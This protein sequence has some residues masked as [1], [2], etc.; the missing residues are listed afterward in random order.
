MCIYNKHKNIGRRYRHLLRNNGFLWE[1]NGSGLVVLRG[2]G[3]S[4]FV[5]P[6]FF[7]FLHAGIPKMS[8]KIF[9]C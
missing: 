9:D 4:V 2:V 3:S 5:I 1:E 6:F 7:F 8:G